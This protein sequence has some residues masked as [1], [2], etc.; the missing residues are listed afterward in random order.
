MSRSIA[1]MNKRYDEVMK[2]T[3]TTIRCTQETLD[4][5]KFMR[6]ATRLSTS[7]IIGGLVKDFLSEHRKE[8]EG[9]LA[10]REQTEKEGLLKTIYKNLEKETLGGDK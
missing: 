2:Y 5:L 8:L 10:N 4:D 6:E 7:S 9:M 1:E 3:R